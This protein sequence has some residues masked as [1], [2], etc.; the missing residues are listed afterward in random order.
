MKKYVTAKEIKQALGIT[1]ETL[2]VWTSSG[3]LG[4]VNMGLHKRYDLDTYLSTRIKDAKLLSDSKL[5][6]EY[7][8]LFEKIR[9]RF[10]YYKKG[11]GKQLDS[12]EMLIMNIT[13][14]IDSYYEN[15]EDKIRLL[16]T[17][18]DNY[19]DRVNNKGDETNNDEDE[20]DEDDE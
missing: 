16:D 20:D 7:T 17:I 19:S 1:N 5:F 14:L 6:D 13:N 12:E 11:K 2:R 10:K 15:I 18:Q 3:K 4:Y 8:A 9:K